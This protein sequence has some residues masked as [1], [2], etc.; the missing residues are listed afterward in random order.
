MPDVDPNE[1]SYIMG[2][3]GEFQQ[4]LR[5]RN[6]HSNAAHLL[7]HLKPGIRVLDFGCG[8]GSITLGLATAVDPGEVHGVDKEQSQVEFAR[9]AAQAGGHANAFFHVADVTA[10]P[11]DDD[12]FDAAH[13]H[14]LLMHLPDTS[15]VLSEVKRVLKPGG[16]IASREMFVSSSF[17]APLDESMDEAWNVFSK[18]LAANG[19]H[20]ELGAQLRTVF[21]EEGFSNVQVG[22]SFDFFGNED[23]VNFIHAF[24]LDWFYAPNV[25]EAA[26]EAGLATQQQFDHWRKQLDLW[27]DDPGACGGF[28]FGH[29]VATNPH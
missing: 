23:E 15:K 1:P 13:C 17:F 12:F 28:A 9:A 11:F 19:G 27:K 26:I 3:S 10:L 14:A 29:V 18:L 8:P 21:Q 22:A 25:T 16:I 24:V 4:L 5:R 6:A 2:Y 20:P 7:P